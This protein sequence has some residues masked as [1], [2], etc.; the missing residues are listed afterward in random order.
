[1]YIS[2]LGKRLTRQQEAPTR[3]LLHSGLIRR[4]FF[5][6][7]INERLS[8]CILTQSAGWNYTILGAQEAKEDEGGG[9]GGMTTSEESQV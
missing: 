4:R 2:Q 8:K 1:M 6:I 7:I 3:K 5:R 9:D